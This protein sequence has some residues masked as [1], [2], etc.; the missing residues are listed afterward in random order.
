MFRIAKT[1]AE[2]PRATMRDSPGRVVVAVV[3]VVDESPKGA[4]Y[5]LI[6]FRRPKAR[7]NRS[8]EEC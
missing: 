7:P 1:L 2:N 5:G 6:L 3:V 8:K 4:V